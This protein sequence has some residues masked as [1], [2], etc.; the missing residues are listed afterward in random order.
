MGFAGNCRSNSTCEAKAPQAATSVRLFPCAGS[1][2]G[3]D[4]EPPRTRELHLADR[5]SAPG[6][7]PPPQYE[8]VLL[9]F[10]V[11]RRFDCV[12]EKTK[13]KVVAEYERLKG[14]KVQ[15]IHLMVDL[16]FIDD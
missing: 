6:T 8:R 7:V 14:G 10:V 1:T 11:L 4:V 2:E 9:P 15:V 13:D 16:L 3:P 5:G 12:L